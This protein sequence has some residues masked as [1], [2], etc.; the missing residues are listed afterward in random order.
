MVPSFAGALIWTTAVAVLAIF[1]AEWY[2]II[3]V[4]MQGT[5]SWITFANIGL[6]AVAV[7]AIFRAD[8]LTEVRVVRCFF[9]AHTAAALPW[10]AAIP[11]HACLLAHGSTDRIGEVL[12][13][14]KHFSEIWGIDNK[15][16]AKFP[17]SQTYA[18]AT[19][20]YDLVALETGT[21]I[22]SSALPERFTIHLAERFAN[23]LRALIAV[24]SVPIV[25]RANSWRG[26]RPI[27]TGSFTDR[28]ADVLRFT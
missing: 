13:H 17:L 4:A 16:H 1:F 24:Q 2:A 14:L 10:L 20:I 19:S 7:H 5:I 8:R 18:C 15:R 28:L 23:V 6:V 21:S 27:Y 12:R 11:V 22:R 9:V 26:A 25:T 3:R